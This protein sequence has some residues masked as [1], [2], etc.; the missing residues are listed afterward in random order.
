MH[1]LALRETLPLRRIIIVSIVGSTIALFMNA[2]LAW[3]FIA[4]CL[5]IVDTSSDS[6]DFES[7]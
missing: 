6:D 4:V 3:H 7:P 5:I 1:V 2:M